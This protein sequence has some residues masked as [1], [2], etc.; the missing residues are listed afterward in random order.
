MKVAV[1][2]EMVVEL[3][4]AVGPVRIVVGREKVALRLFVAVQQLAVE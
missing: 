1:W 3:L 4:K 2:K